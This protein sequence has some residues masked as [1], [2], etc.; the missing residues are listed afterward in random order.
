MAGLPGLSL[1]QKSPGD[2]RF[3]RSYDR[4]ALVAADAGA[5]ARTRFI[6]LT[7]ANL[8]GA[9]LAFMGIEAVLLNLPQ[10]PAWCRR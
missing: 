9:I 7:Y 6:R 2:E 1:I 5:D 4:S 8:A 3:C 10:T